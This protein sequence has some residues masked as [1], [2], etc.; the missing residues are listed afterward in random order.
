MSRATSRPCPDRLRR[1]VDAFAGRRVAVLADLVA[2]EFIYGDI[3][4][5]SREAPVLILNEQR[6]VRSPGGG[7]NAIANLRALGAAPLPVGVVGDDEGGRFLV[8]AFE[9]DGVSTRGIASVADYATPVKSRILAGGV[10]TRRQQI[11]RID[12]GS[13]RGQALD[14]RLGAKLDRALTRATARAEGLLIADY[15]YEAATP[16]RARPAIRDLARNGRPTTVDSRAR[17]VD[18]RGI[19]ACTPNLEELEQAAAGGALSSP[20]KIANAA[21]SLRDTMRA[22]AILV[23]LGSEGMALFPAEGAT[24]RVPAYGSDEVADVTGAGDTVVATFTLA[25]ASGAEAADAARLAN[26]AA[27]I[28]VQKAGTATLSPDELQQAIEEDLT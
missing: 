24:L 12:R 11:V 8:E 2:D 5:V 7:G 14:K 9:A 25:L 1:C 23:T 16:R 17:I 22:R 3:E 28:V 27:G 15:G 4:R 13:G 20:P 6:V 21:S 26:Y 18:Y 19:T 10:H